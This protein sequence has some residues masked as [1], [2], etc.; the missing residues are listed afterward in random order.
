MGK[1]RNWKGIFLACFIC[2]F[3][4]TM[5]ITGGYTPL[6]HPDA[7]PQE[8]KM[9]D[10]YIDHDAPKEKLD[11]A[12]PQEKPIINT[13]SAPNL[14][15]INDKY[16]YL[17]DGNVLLP[18]A[19]DT[20]NEYEV[21]Y[22]TKAPVLADEK[23]GEKI[24]TISEYYN[25]PK[26]KWTQ[27]FVMQQIQSEDDCQ[28]FVEKLIT[29]I[30]VS[31]DDQMRAEGKTLSKDNLEF[32]FVRKNKDDTILFWH[33]KG[34]AKTDDET[35]FLRCFKGTVTGKKILATFTMKTTELTEQQITQFIQTM[36]QIIE[37]REKKN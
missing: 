21:T 24:G 13:V 36:T 26:D 22:P 14:L 7:M 35:Q 12:K 27:K 5:I 19:A 1:E 31:L 25:E 32:S 2:A 9:A 34:I 15:K 30:I 28:Q 23:P 17:F 20:W 11:T 3:S 10:D 4:G 29:G 33:K 8:R 16:M 18:L 6:S 37:L